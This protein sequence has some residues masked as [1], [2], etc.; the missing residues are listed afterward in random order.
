[1]CGPSAAQNTVQADQI[2]LTNQI[3]SENSTVF[4]ESQGILQTL[5]STYAP[6][7]AQGPNQTGFSNAEDTSLNTEAT[8]QTAENFSQAQRT[9]QENQDAQGGGN[10]FEPGGE[11]ASEDE[12]LA[13]TAESSQSAEQSQILQANY[14]QGRQNFNTAAGVLGGVATTLNPVGTASTAVSS[15]AAAATTANTIAAQSNSIWTSVLGALGGV[16]G[17]AVGDIP[18]G[19]PTPASSGSVPSVPMSMFGG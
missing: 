4:G 2:N 5:N 16:A 3:M 18:S 13:A 17:E 12:S 7:L 19:T 6:I 8:D 15:G 1:M 9:L 14:T 10:N 11:E